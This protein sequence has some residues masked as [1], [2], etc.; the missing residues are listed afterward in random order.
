MRIDIFPE[1]QVSANL[2]AN[3]TALRNENFPDYSVPRSYGKQLPNLRVLAFE[4]EKLVG[5]LGIDHRVM[6]FG[7]TPI[8][9]FGVI[10]LCVDSR[11]RGQGIGTLLL[12][13][14]EGVA[15]SAEIN[16]LI[17]MADDHRIYEK[18]GFELFN[19]ECSWL[20]IDEH[21]QYGV[22]TEN[23]SGELMI[24]TLSPDLKLEGPVDFLGYMF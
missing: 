13:K 8:S 17:L 12:E 23:F 14:V 24:K 10:D 7:Q 21:Q 2:H 1:Y 19:A 9:T 20:R 4:E 11:L 5:Y 6:R 3:I 15:L 22:G 18:F 16:A